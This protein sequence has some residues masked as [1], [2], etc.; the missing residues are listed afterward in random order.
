MTDR[1][2]SVPVELLNNL[3]ALIDHNIGFESHP[4]NELRALLATPVVDEQHP[5]IKCLNE[6][7]ERIAANATIAQQAEYIRLLERDA[8]RYRVLRS[9][10][11]FAL[12]LGKSSTPEQIDALCDLALRP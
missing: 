1:T 3:L 10:P 5:L 2:I 11:T 12:T 7:G 9:T 4:A 6:N 8:G